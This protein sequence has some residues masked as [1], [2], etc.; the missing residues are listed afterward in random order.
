MIHTW[1]ITE[2]FKLI[3]THDDGSECA[4]LGPWIS[5]EDVELW[6]VPEVL[7]NWCENSNENPE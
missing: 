6:I 2:D 1:E 3:I 5:R 7:S 4:T